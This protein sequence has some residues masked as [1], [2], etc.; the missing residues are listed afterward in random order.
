MLNTNKSAPIAPPIAPPMTAASIE[1]DGAVTCTK[2]SVVVV[3]FVVDDE[4]DVVEN[5]IDNDIDI[6]ELNVLVEDVGEVDDPV[7]PAFDVDGVVLDVDVDGVVVPV[8][9]GDVGGVGVVDG[10]GGVVVGL[11]VVVVVGR[12]TGVGGGVQAVRVQSHLLVVG[13]V[14]QL[15]QLSPPICNSLHAKLEWD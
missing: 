13:T 11:V 3:A 1:D 15:K 8:V 6:N 7:S 5:N 14:E 10:R 2:L 4:S 9:V 12:G